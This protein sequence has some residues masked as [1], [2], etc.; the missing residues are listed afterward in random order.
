MNLAQV[1]VAVAIAPV[2]SPRLRGFTGLLDPLDTLARSSPGFVWRPTLDEVDPAEL[3]VF[4][5]L[6]RV[7]P[8]VSV[9]TS[10]EALRAFTYDSRHREAVR[11]RR[12]WFQPPDGPTTALWWVAEGE[13]PT[14]AEAHRRY[15]FLREHG[16]TPE[17][18]TLKDPFPE[19]SP[20]RE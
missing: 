20:A 12:R 17:A 4:G 5:D 8:N 7:V 1:N 19:P 14:F 2:G 10:V 3:A 9:W 6:R 11:Q 18:F 13:T 15:R 16:P